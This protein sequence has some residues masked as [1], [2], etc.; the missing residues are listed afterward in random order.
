MLS[1]APPLRAVGAFL[2]S[3]W[4]RCRLRP[5]VYDRRRSSRRFPRRGGTLFQLSHV[6]EKL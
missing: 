5:R 6:T 3:A 4:G 1:P 2:L